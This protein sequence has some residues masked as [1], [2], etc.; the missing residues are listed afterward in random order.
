MSA[1]NIRVIFEPD[2]LSTFFSKQTFD[3]DEDD[4]DDDDEREYAQLEACDDNITIYI[5]ACQMRPE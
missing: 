2:V 3:D 5:H 4:D 1:W